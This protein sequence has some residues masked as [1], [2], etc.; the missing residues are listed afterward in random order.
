MAGINSFFSELSLM[1][2]LTMRIVTI[3]SIAMNKDL[4]TLHWRDS[5]T[6]AGPMPLSQTSM[7]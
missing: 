1:H 4:K 6:Q 2:T 3:N 7:A 5:V